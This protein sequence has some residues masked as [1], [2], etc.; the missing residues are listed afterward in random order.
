MEGELGEVL[1]D[2]RDHAGVVRAR[3]D[4]AEEDLVAGNKELDAEDA[5]PAEGAGH[6]GRDPLGLLLGGGRHRLR[7]PA[8]AV[9]AVLLDV[10]DR[11]AERD[12]AG[13]ADGQESDLVVEVDEA[14]DDHPAGTGAPGLSG[15][16]PRG[17]SAVGFADYRLALPAGRH[18]RLDHAR[19]AQIGDGGL[20]LLSRVAEAERRGREAKLL[21]GQ[22]ADPLTVHGQAGGPRR[23]HD[24]KA[25]SLEALELAGGDRLE[26]RNDHQLGARPCHL[27]LEQGRQCAR[28][29]HVDHLEAVGHLHRGGAGVA[30]DGHHLA[31]EPLG[32]E[33]D[34]TTQLPRP[35]EHEPGRVGAPRRADRQRHGAGA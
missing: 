15:V 13:V 12:T 3:G 23:G 10:T 1:G 34:L 24:A 2:H 27:R 14:L 5:G 31:S 33:G 20:D 4:L 35:E 19:D 18:H 17:S 25:L 7:L 32:L 26:L 22:P 29:G 11:C 8:L 30:V 28:V 16:I 6:L 9:V 21:G